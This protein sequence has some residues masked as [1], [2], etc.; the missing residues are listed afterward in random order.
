MEFD[1]RDALIRDIIKRAG[2]ASAIA[3][4]APADAPVTI[5]AVY[6]WPKIGIPDRHWPW[7]M[8]L[9]GV[10]ADELLTANVAARSTTEAAA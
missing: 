6:K 4:A 8:Q 3:A 2:G 7:I 10:T 1:M 9:A 5:E